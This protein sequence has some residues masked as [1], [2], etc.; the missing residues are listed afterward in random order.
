MAWL[1]KYKQ[2]TNWWIGY[3]VGGK[4]RAKSTGTSDRAEAQR[5]L[6]KFQQKVG[7]QGRKKGTIKLTALSQAE[8]G[9]LLDSFIHGRFEDQASI[10]MGVEHFL[11]QFDKI[12]KLVF[13]DREQGVKSEHSPDIQ[14]SEFSRI[15][16]ITK[17]VV[18]AT[19][20]FADNLP[21]TLGLSSVCVL[22]QRVHDRDADFFRKLAEYLEM[23]SGPVDNL[24][25]EILIL[26]NS[27]EAYG[28]SASGVQKLLKSREVNA[29]LRTI[30]RVLREF[31]LN[32][33]R[34]GSKRSPTI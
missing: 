33:K 26:S 22:A 34:K 14:P 5:K 18:N 16:Q 32:Q 23:P 7:R 9:E 28:L 29:D 25:G 21:L 12:C 15:L 13:Q 17:E 24:R 2:S 31:G 8:R 11:K 30:Q 1:Y 27:I 20:K 4:Q 19:F 10:E 3:R 6:E